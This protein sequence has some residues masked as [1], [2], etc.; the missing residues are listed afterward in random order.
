MNTVRRVCGHILVAVMDKEGK[1]LWF[2]VR[3]MDTFR[4]TISSVPVCFQSSSVYHKLWIHIYITFQP[5][6][7]NK[8]SLADVV[9]V[10]SMSISKV[11]SHLFLFTSIYDF[12]LL[13][14]RVDCFV[15]KFSIHWF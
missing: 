1:L 8:T 9:V 10:S 2:E 6:T 7:V 12:L 15:L 13:T 5:N 11:L 3:Y 4:Q 14:V